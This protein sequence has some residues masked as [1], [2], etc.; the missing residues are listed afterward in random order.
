[1]AKKKKQKNLKTAFIIIFIAFAC[2]IITGGVKY[3]LDT[4]SNAS[5]SP[6]V[7]NTN[8]SAE[9]ELPPAPQVIIY[10]AK[11]LDTGTYL[12][13]VKVDYKSKQAQMDFAL[14]EL[15]KAKKTKEYDPVMPE[16]TK[17]INPITVKGNIA[18]VDFN[19]SFVD[20]FSGGSDME[21][22]TL[23]AIAHTVVTNSDETVDKVKILVEGKDVETLGGH[24]ELFEPIKPDNVLLAP[25][26]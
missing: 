23:N 7:D 22:L 6:S 10:L 18:F 24:F 3:Y 4:R 16:R 13:P 9:E 11:T 26:K 5:T 25:K 2:A 20:N 15:I 12:V 1:M 17:L 21:A 8:I 14:N 19:Q